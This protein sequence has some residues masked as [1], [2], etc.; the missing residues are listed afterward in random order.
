MAAELPRRRP[1][2]GSLERPVSTRIYRVA[3]LAVAVPVLVAAFSVGRPDPLPEPRLRPFFDGPTAAQFARELVLCCPDRSPG[4][5]KAREA[6][7]WVEQRL[8]DYRF[9]VERQTFS[10]DI[11]GRG[12][13]TLVNVVAVAPRS[14]R[15]PVR[16]QQTIVVMAHRDNLGLSPG[17]NDNA[18]GTAAL[19]ELAR[20]VGDAS[21]VHKFV[22]VS[23]DGGAFGSLG[24]A[25]FAESPRYAGRIVAV[26]NLDAV[27]GSG[28]PRI[29]FASDNSRVP[30]PTLLATAD[31]SVRDHAG[32]LPSRP[33]AVGQLLDL[34]FPFSFGGQAPFVARGAPAVT[35]TTGGERP[36]DAEGDTLAALDAERLEDLGRSA[37]ALLGSLDEAAEVARGTDS[38]VYFGTRILHGWT[39]QFVLL[40]ALLPFLAATIDLFARCRRRRIPLA[41]A[42]RSYASRLGVWLWAG[43]AFALFS[44]VGILPSGADRPLALE[45]QVASDWPA[46]ALAALAVVSALGWLVARPRLAPARSISREEELGGHLAGMLVLAVVALVVAAANPYALVF[47]LPALHAWLWLPQ[48]SDRGR[49]AQLALYAA[50]FAGPL[51]LV[52]SFALRFE[53]GLDA[54][55]YLLALTAIGYVPVPLVLAFLAWGAAA[56]QTGAM[57]LGR[58]APYPD[59]SERP[60]RGPLREAV[61]RL[62]LLGRRTR[63]RRGLRAVDGGVSGEQGER[64]EE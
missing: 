13:E 22:F 38:Y 39:V 5:P 17:A 31:E 30:S 3:W 52:G 47:V 23:T 26:V 14:P 40:A 8:R 25:A 19:L 42:L 51:L 10:A 36:P 32:V 15:E 46:A 29:A 58:Y 1:R 59:A 11:P 64:L 33:G 24:A 50:G 35:I 48:V 49:G 61:R 20:D 44:L 18:S 37:Q 41:P 6:A 27:A 4:S 53:L 7:A 57:A 63:S 21:L 16:S 54:L 28:A 62:V 9:D 45:T 43:A 56:G 34:A 2:R 55:W 12:K 60:A